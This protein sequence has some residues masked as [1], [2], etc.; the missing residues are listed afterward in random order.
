MKSYDILDYRGRWLLLDYMKTDRP[1]SKP[2]SKELG[3]IE[4]PPGREGGDSVDCPAA[5]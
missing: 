1:A 3:P 4:G 5:G 2:L